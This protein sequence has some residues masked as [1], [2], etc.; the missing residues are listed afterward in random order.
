MYVV[1]T[2]PAV[3]PVSVAEAK[4]H[5]RV[6]GNTED[7]LFTSLIKAAREYCEKRSKR[8]FITTTYRLDAYGFCSST[9]PIRI[10]KG[11][12]IAVSYVKYYD[13][14]GTL[15]TI[16]SSNYRVDVTPLY[17]QIVPISTYVWPTVQEQRPDAVQI[18][19]TAGY[20]AAATSVP[21]AVKTAIKMLVSGWYENRESVTPGSISVV[22]F[23]VDHLI[24][25]FAAPEF[26]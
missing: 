23:A 26:Y 4:L 20:G 25:T 16:T 5:C 10:D 7:D 17:G 13:T 21:D 14:A 1:T 15:T 9:G 8:T 11:P 19:F 2:P 18:S 12:L 22:P 3:E 6:D 24:A